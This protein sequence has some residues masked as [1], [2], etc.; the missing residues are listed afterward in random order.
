MWFHHTGWLNCEI[1]SFWCLGKGSRPDK[2][3]DDY[4]SSLRPVES[5][6]VQLLEHVACCSMRGSPTVS[7][8]E[9]FSPTLGLSI[10]D[11]TAGTLLLPSLQ[12][13]ASA[14]MNTRAPCR[15]GAPPAKQAARQH[16]ST[17]R[18]ST[19]VSGFHCLANFCHGGPKKVSRTICPSITST[20]LSSVAM[21]HSQPEELEGGSGNVDDP[22]KRRQ[23]DGA[24]ENVE[25]EEDAGI[26]QHSTWALLKSQD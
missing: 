26:V 3:I 17:F 20:P 4:G 16:L 12:W 11:G 22:R 10:P 8:R 15:P 6:R 7:Q 14:Q 9:L 21:T 24:H 23:L 18:S 19:F 5:D 25:P 13:K 1:E 2:A